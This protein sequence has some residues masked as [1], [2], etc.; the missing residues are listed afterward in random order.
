LTTNLFFK[1]N[2][3]KLGKEEVVG[4]IEEGYP[5]NKSSLLRRGLSF[6]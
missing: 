2:K 4:K 5:R 3:V 1:Y 6:L